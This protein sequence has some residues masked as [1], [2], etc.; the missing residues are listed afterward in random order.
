MPL[1][2]NRFVQTAGF[3]SALLWSA[4]M[5]GPSLAT[6]LDIDSCDKL[7][8][9]EQ[10]LQQAGIA[11]ILAN[12]PEWAK[13]NAGNKIEQ[14][15]QLI[16]IEEAIAFRCLRP[17]PLPAQ[18]MQAL[19]VAA[20]AAAPKP[21]PKPKPVTSAANGG[22]APPAG[23]AT[24]DAAAT[25]AAKPKPKPVVKAAPPAKPVDAYGTAPPKP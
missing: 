24:G 17:K 18:S 6:P 8:Q 9:Q 13:A 5:A 10:A 1:I 21:K 12:G 20:A 16:E 25:V 23:A 19:P 7:A 11:T 4:S 15:K 3:A 2:P 22:A 14:V